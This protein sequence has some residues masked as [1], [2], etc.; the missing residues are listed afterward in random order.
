MSG[1]DNMRLIRTKNIF[2][3]ARVC[4][5]SECLVEAAPPTLTPRVQ[6]R[7]S[8]SSA[9]LLLLFVLVFAFAVVFGVGIVWWATT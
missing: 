4:F 5:G 1:S 8:I 7:V 9:E 2:G 3:S 6:R